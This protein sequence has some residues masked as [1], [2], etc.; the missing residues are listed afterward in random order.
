M[1]VLDPHYRSPYEVSP[2][3]S[4]TQQLPGDVRLTLTYRASYGVH[5]RRTPNINAPHPGTP[6]PDEILDLPRSE[7]QEII[8]RMRPLYPHIGNITQI[9]TVGRSV[10]RTVRVRAQPRGELELFGIELSGNLNYTYRRADDDNDYNNPYIRQWG[11]SRR[12]HEVGSQFRIGLPDRVSFTSPVLRALARATYEAANLN[13]RFRANTG[14]LY[15]LRSGRDLNGDQSTRDRPLGVA[16]NS[17]T[18]P[19]S[20]NI[21]MTFTK[22]F[23]PGVGTGD[24]GSEGRGGGEGRGR[25]RRS[26]GPRIRFQARIDNLLNRT[27]PRGYGSVVT[28][29]LFGLP[30]GYAAGRTVDLSLSVDF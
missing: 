2:Q 25:G 7:R 27:Q 13:F 9:Q 23:E 14:R 29:P 11:S 22:D 8:D 18:G 12:D 1:W 16:R 21:D 3:V 15:S 17:E 28:S 19:G 20:W 6:L 4:V 26:E 24:G 30:T 10:D 5:Q